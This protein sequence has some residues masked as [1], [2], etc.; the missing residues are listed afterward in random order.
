[1]ASLPPR[2]VLVTRETDYERLL[3][4]HATREQARFFLKSRGQDLEPLIARHEA[5]HATMHRVRLSIPDSWR[6]AKAAR[7]DLDRFLFAPEDVVVVVGQD[8]LVA[9]L[10]KYLG[11][12][13]VIGVNPAP[14]LFEGVLVPVRAEELR[15]LLPAAA[16]GEAAIERRT[17]AEAQLDSGQTLTALNEIFIGHR[18]H[19]SAR[20]E[21][22]LAGKREPQ[23]SSGVIVSTGTG[24]TGWARS[25]MTATHHA[26]KLGP[27]DPTLGVFVREPWP[28]VATAASITAG[29]V[30]A[31]QPLV[32]TSQMNDGGVIFADG[33][34]QDRLEFGWGRRVQVTVARQTLNLVRN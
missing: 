17:M 13:P 2:A 20:Y 25:I 30:D 27:T 9:N 23:S 15:P 24:A 21:I 6:I 16:A 7:A 4:V 19:Q 26:L 33:I 28:S 3:A 11:G 18:S 1:M 8:G 29:P 34:E 5:F 10:A 14:D 22:E 32:V 12:Q 31:R